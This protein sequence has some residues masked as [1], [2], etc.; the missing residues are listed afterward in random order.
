MRPPRGRAVAA[1]AVA[2]GV[3]LA[4][5]APGARAQDAGR[6]DAGVR[7][8]D[9]SAPQAPS[10]AGPQAPD[11][12]VTVRAADAGPSRGG[13]PPA[14][15]VD[16]GVPDAGV[17][18]PGPGDEIPL[19]DDDDDD[20]G[21]GDGASADT[22]DGEGA[23]HPEDTDGADDDDDGD[24]EDTA[25]RPIRYF[26]ERVDVRGNSRTSA[27]VVRRFVPIHRGE[28]LD[29]DDP[30]IETIRWRLLGTGWFNDV[31]LRLLRGVER[32]WVVLVIDVEERNTLVVQSVSFGVSE[33][34]RTSADMTPSLEP[35]VGAAV[36]DTNLFGTGITVSASTL[37]SVPQQGVRLRFADPMF[38]GSEFGFDASLFFNNSR[39]FFGGENDTL[40]SIRC[41][42]IDPPD[43]DPPPC[44]PEVEARNAVVLYRRYG[45]SL[46]TGH[47]MGATTRYTLDW[48]GELVDVLVKPD[49]ASERR[50]GG[51]RSEVVPIDCAIDNGV[52]LVST[53]QL[54]LIFDRRDDPALPS[55]GT[56]VQFRGDV[57]SRIIFSDYDFLRMEV[58]ARQW[59]PLP[60]GHVL[61]LSGFAGAIFGRA[62]FFYKFYVADLSDLIPSRVL[63]MN[64]D[65]R[66][67]P[68]IFGTAIAEIRTGEVAARIDV[69][70][71]VP[72]FRGGSGFRALDA[73]LNV[74]TY[75][76][77]GRRDLQVA[78]PGY[79]GLSRIPID[80][81]FDLGVRAD[82]DIGVF[83][84]GFSNLFGF[85]EL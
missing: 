80:L 62:P 64:L 51:A 76:L 25:P 38:L 56:L 35:Y 75:A 60:W 46:G 6:T 45:A 12:A 63:E 54:G 65:R 84:L 50:G 27:A 9:A 43:P 19:P 53:I 42:A 36:A 47:D 72:L 26:L 59:I 85:I 11:A 22:G 32:G 31:R 15:P 39:E 28:V 24:D 57:G 34:V 61:R 77:A 29:V 37:V 78:I 10:D 8:S 68:D 1:V 52:S 13:A 23:G 20:D 5:S 2:L 67:P 21:D 3:A 66:A 73:Y 58:L 83:Q 7:V 69:E 49:A 82:T 44:P 74:G 41:P 30:A 81:T 70:Y 17:R 48:Q 40:V 33:G 18:E 4:A 71:N 79:D 16:A 55:R 14:R